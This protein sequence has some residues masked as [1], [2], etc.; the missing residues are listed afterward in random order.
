MPA[1]GAY[2][3]GSWVMWQHPE[4]G[5]ACSGIVTSWLRDNQTV[6][7]GRNGRAVI[8]SD[9]SEPVVIELATGAKPTGGPWKAVYAPRV[10][11]PIQLGAERL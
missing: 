6:G 1:A 7:G 9:G 8:P 3:P 4:T 2:S 10:S 5:Q 11:S